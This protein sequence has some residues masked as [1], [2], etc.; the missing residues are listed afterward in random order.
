MQVRLY[1]SFIVFLCSVFTVY[2]HAQAPAATGPASVTLF[3]NVRVLSR[4]GQLTPPTNVLVRGNV[5]ES[6][7]TSPIPT[8]RSATAKII[9]GG[10]RTLVP[11]LI[12]AHAHILMQSI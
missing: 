4:T 6:I 7:S 11:G 2:L 5:I 12:D 3:Q 8:D 9:E 10:G 1:Q